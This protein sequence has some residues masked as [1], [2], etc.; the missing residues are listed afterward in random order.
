MHE[1]AWTLSWGLGAKPAAVC[2]PLEPPFRLIC[3]W[4]WP[5]PHV[6]LFVPQRVVSLR[7]G[8]AE[9]NVLGCVHLLKVHFLDT[10]AT[11]GAKCSAATCH[12]L[13]LSSAGCWVPC[14]RAFGLRA[15]SLALAQGSCL[16]TQGF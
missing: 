1:H 13:A 11:T 16:L 6:T 10:T 14:L 7:G 12:L 5:A 15:L 2:Y 4:A 8:V 9:I 3:P